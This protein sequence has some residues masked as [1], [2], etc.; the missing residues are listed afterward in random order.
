M[1]F[2]N[3][4]NVFSNWVRL[5][6]SLQVVR[7]NL[8][9]ECKCHG[10]TGGCNLKTCLKQLA[11]FTVIGS[12]LKQ[13]YRT[14]VRVSFLNNKLHKR[15]NNRDRLVTRKLKKLVY[16]DSSP[17]YCVRND[18][19][20]SPGMLGRSCRSDV[21]PTKECR[22]LCNSCQLRHQTVEH[23]KQVKCRCKFLWCCTVKCH[24]CT[25]KYSL[26]TCTK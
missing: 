5:V 16:L 22:S 6:H 8:K 17:V 19:A 9:K 3:E 18:T 14:A 11:R 20:G 2:S 12:E 4:K 10:V 24:L 1:K 7:A 25:V 15:D 26:T 23:D 13:K 21:V